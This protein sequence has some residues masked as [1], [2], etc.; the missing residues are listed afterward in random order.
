MKKVSVIPVLALALTLG[1]SSLVSAQ[2][3]GRPDRQRA[4]QQDSTHRRGV[5]RRG[6]SDGFLLRGIT[7]SASQQARVKTLRESERKQ[8]EANFLRGQAGKPQARPERQR[9][10]TAGMGA[11][12]AQMQ[13]FR[14][15]RI[16]ALRTILSSDQRTQFDKNVAEMKAHAGDRRGGGAFGGEGRGNR[17]SKPQR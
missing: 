5:G 17:D 3:A 9:G 11:R 7:L 8:M 10:D 12:R 15:K 4:E 2:S 16:A 13:Q 14:E 1:T 6:G